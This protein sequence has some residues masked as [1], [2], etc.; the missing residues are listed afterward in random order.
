MKKNI[1]ISIFGL[2]LS[3]INELKVIIDNILGTDYSIYWTNIADTNLQVLIINHD[4]FDLPNIIKIKKDNIF[5]LKVLNNLNLA[6]Q[7]QEQNLYL[8]LTDQLP[9]KNWLFNTV[10]PSLFPSNTATNISKDEHTK[11]IH[12]THFQDILLQLNQE[13]AK[14]KLLLLDGKIKI[15]LI[16]PLANTIWIDP[17]FKKNTHEIPQLVHADLNSIIHFRH[18]HT[19]QDLQSGLWQ[20]IWDHLSRE[21]PIY[22]GCY[23]LKHWP[24]PTTNAERKDILKLS[25]YFQQG[26]SIEYIQQQLEIS[27]DF[28]QR[29]LFISSLLNLIEE[30]SAHKTQQY[31]NQNIENQNVENRSSVRNFFSRLRK[32]LSI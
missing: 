1:N 27:P 29:Y 21:T 9:L 22:H 31:L 17:N 25:A 24:Q 11:K 23:R 18:K 28:I 6:G 30:I 12:Y 13:E 2:N 16:D 4:F 7:I 15:A 10:I 19:A 20:W 8:P 3:R 32:K 26:N 14:S 5:I